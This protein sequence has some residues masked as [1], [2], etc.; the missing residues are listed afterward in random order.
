MVLWGLLRLDNDTAVSASVAGLGKSATDSTCAQLHGWQG[1]LAQS[2]VQCSTGRLTYCWTIIVCQTA[3]LVAE[4]LYHLLLEHRAK[5]V[6]R[7]LAPCHHHL[8][9]GEH[10]RVQLM[11]ASQGP[12]RPPSKSQA[13]GLC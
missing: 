5:A 8:A 1:L 12:H 2:T 13:L 6:Q 9:L 7:V 10:L 3:H 4:Q 11:T